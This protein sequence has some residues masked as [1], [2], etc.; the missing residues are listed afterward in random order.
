MKTT[1]VRPAGRFPTRR[2]VSETVSTFDTVEDFELPEEVVIPSSPHTF[3]TRVEPIDGDRINPVIVL[4]PEVQQHIYFIIK[5]CGEDEISWL[6]T[7]TQ[8]DNTYTIDRVFL[9]KQ[10]VSVVE[11][12]IDAKVLGKFYSDYIKKGGSTSMLNKI[13]FWGHVH[14]GE[15]TEPSGQD[16]TQMELFAHN[17]YFIRGI[18]NRQGRACFDFYDYTAKIKTLDCPWRL[19]YPMHNRRLEKKVKKEILKK[20]SPC[21]I[22][23]TTS[24]PDVGFQAPTNGKYRYPG[25]IG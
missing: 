21:E 16:D 18:F 3:E 11:T 5:N 1:I 9:F 13:L 22:G 23:D 25:Q 7:V 6:G 2:E 17:K 15:S 4:T 10:S 14:P 19:E 8:K 20:V 24:Y 12:E